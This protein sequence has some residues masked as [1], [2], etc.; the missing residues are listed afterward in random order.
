MIKV[1]YNDTTGLILGFYPDN[2]GYKTT[3]MPTIEITVEQHL[4]CIN[5]PGLRKVDIDTM[6]IVTC[7]LP[8]TT[9][10]ELLS[11]IRVKRDSLLA[12]C[13]WT[14]LSDVPLTEEKKDQWRIYRQALRDMPGN[15][16]PANPVWP[17]KP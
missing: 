13:D 1:N 16:D 15:C 4:D 6:Q 2:I 11:M 10:D 8:E 3:P 9:T 5:N 7:T 17:E 14:V 12:E